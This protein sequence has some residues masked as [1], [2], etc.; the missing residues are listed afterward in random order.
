MAKALPRFSKN[1]IFKFSLCFLRSVSRDV[2][3]SKHL[4]VNRRSV[5]PRLNSILCS[6]TTVISGRSD[7]YPEISTCDVKFS[8]R[9]LSW[10]VS[11]T[12]IRVLDIYDNNRD[13]LHLHRVRTRE[14]NRVEI[15][16]LLIIIYIE[17]K[18]RCVR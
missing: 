17:Y 12:R 9:P 15:K 11:R 13:E 3:N 4:E 14:Y 18:I 16:Y 2:C 7:I 10:H 5:A 1:H 8:H 6:C